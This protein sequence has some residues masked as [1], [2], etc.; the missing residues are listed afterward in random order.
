MARVVFHEHPSQAGTCLPGAFA[1]YMERIPVGDYQDLD[2]VWQHLRAA[3]FEAD[4]G[5]TS[6][7][8]ERCQPVQRSR[9][10][11]KRFNC[12]EA[13]AHFAAA[14]RRLLPDTFAVHVWDR[15]LPNG[16]RHVWPSL[17]TPRGQHLL[18]D[19]QTVVPPEHDPGAYNGILTEPPANATEW[20][21]QVL[22]AVHFT[23]DKVLRVF[24]LGDL[25]DQIEPA[26][27]DTLPDWSKNKKPV[28]KEAEPDKK[29]ARKEA[30]PDNK[31][32]ENRPEESSVSIIS[33]ALRQRY[34]GVRPERMVRMQQQPDVRPSEQTENLMDPK[35][36]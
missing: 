20:W 30:E 32:E 27:G 12:W 13:T 4:W 16:A 9:I 35:V 17:V 28:R 15:Q 18:V 2:E 31:R 14:A 1:Q 10:W 19:L 3:P 6:R 25:S 29:T 26:Y 11:P 7:G 24:N 21:N 23:G 22:G 8:D 5:R 33:P 34:R 36:L